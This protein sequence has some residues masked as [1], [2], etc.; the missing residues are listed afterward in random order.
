M[1]SRKNNSFIRWKAL[2]VQ[3][4]VLYPYVVC[5]QQREIEVHSIHTLKRVQTISVQG[6]KSLCLQYAAG[7]SPRLLIVTATGVFA[8]PLSRM[9]ARLQSCSSASPIAML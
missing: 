4:L 5:L 1:P 9:Q 6:A 8:A 2:P 3:V 7:A